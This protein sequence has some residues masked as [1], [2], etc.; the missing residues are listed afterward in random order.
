[1]KEMPLSCLAVMEE[2]ACLGSALQNAECAD[3]VATTLSGAD[4]YHDEN[5]L[6]W[7]AIAKCVSSRESV[8]RLSVRRRM[9]T[10]VSSATLL[11]LE[12]SIPTV[13]H[14]GSYVRS[15]QLASTRRRLLSTL[16]EAERK[17]EDGDSNPTE[18]IADLTHELANGN[19][20]S[21]R[22]FSPVSLGTILREWQKSVDRGPTTRVATPFATLNYY[23]DGGFGPGEM[24][25]LGARPR[26]GKSAF[27]MEVARKASANGVNTLVVSREM[28]R[29][30]VGRWIISQD[31]HIKS[32]TLKKGLLSKEEWSIYANR[33][34][35]LSSL[36]LWVS[37]DVS[38]LDDILRMVD[39]WTG[40]P[41]GLVIVD[42]LQ[43]VSAPKGITERRHQVESV[44]AGLKGLAMR[45][46]IP[47][48][49]LSSL[50]R[51]PSSYQESE[52]TPTLASLKESGNLEHDADT[53]LFLHREHP[54]T[55]D[56]TKL[57][58]AKQKD[59]PTGNIL[60]RLHRETVSFSEVG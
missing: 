35:N 14:I 44:S 9:S 56:D 1:M 57:I 28:Y 17:L 4:F 3:L 33:Y 16:Q 54:D 27:A 39:H 30:V 34:D 45:H 2:R 6:V 20:E 31:T 47:V 53:I 23:L 22:V 48:L 29:L 8:D 13:A 11:D 18:T 42:Y 15:V 12:K 32:S 19:P 55:E 41:L 51:P 26:I 49:C 37:D 46:R 10:L 52:P 43:L 25:F 59:G 60:L 58:I 40:D 38:N 5:R 36:P 50:N 7:E 21:E 24:I